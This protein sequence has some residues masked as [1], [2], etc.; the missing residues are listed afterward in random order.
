MLDLRLIRREP[1][2]V[3][4]ALA[5]GG[6][7]GDEELARAR[8]AAEAAASVVVLKGP[9]TVVAAPDGRAAIAHNAPPWLATAGSGDVLAGF[10]LGLAWLALGTAAFSV[11]REEEARAPVTVLEGAEPEITDITAGEPTNRRARQ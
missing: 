5:R 1:E 6:G 4:A 8:R 2:A 10:V 3:R 11:W 7:E 9:D